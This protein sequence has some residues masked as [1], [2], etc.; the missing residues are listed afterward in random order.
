[1]IRLSLMA[2]SK[3]TDL[4]LRWEADVEGVAFK[5]YIPKWRVPRPWPTRILV[6]ISD[7]GDATSLL[8]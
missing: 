6:R 3:E 4:K 2:P 8:Q 7:I 5:L 1:M